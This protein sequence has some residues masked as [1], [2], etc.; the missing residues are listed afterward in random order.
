MELD[1]KRVGGAIDVGRELLIQTGGGVNGL[2]SSDMSEGPG[3]LMDEKAFFGSGGVEPLGLYSLPLNSG[4]QEQDFSGAV[5]TWVKITGIPPKTQRK[6]GLNGR[7]GTITTPEMGGVLQATPKVDGAGASSF[8]WEGSLQEGQLAGYRAMTSPQM[9]ATLGS[10][11]DEHA[12]IFGPWQHQI[13]GFFGGGAEVIVDPLTQAL[14]N[15][16]RFVL[17]MLNNTI[18]RYPEAFVRWKAAKTS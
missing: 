12:G 15:Q 11:S 13:S 18:N 8:I 17:N 2:V 3:I 10:G 6:N 16:V 1:A 4:I 14:N 9:K 5:P 7:L